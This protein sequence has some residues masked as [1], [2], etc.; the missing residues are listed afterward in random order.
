MPFNECFNE[1]ISKC[2]GRLNILKILANVS[3]CFSSDTLKCV[4]FS[5]IRSIIE[6][7][8]IIFPLISET[9][10]KKLGAI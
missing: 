9:N 3:W 5:L 2:N 7:N 1:I 8:S 6:Y 4:Y 10:K